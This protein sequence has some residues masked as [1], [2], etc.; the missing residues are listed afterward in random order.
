[1]SKINEKQFTIALVVL[2]FI[3][4]FLFIFNTQRNLSYKSEINFSSSQV[5]AKAKH[6]LQ[7]YSLA[8]NIDNYNYS[9]K[10]VNDKLAHLLLKRTLGE[11]EAFEFLQENEMPALE[12]SIRFFKELGQ[13]E[14]LVNIDAS[15]G[16]IISFFKTISEN[17]R[18]QNMSELRARRFVRIYLENKGYDLTKFKERDFL[19]D[20]KEGRVDY[21]FI[22]R[23]ED[24]NLQTE[25]GNMHLEVLISILG[26]KIGGFASYLS[27]PNE[28]TKLIE[29]DTENS[30]FIRMFSIL[31]SIL[32][33]VLAVV[34]LV[35]RYKIGNINKKLFFYIAGFIFTVLLIEV[36]N[37]IPL[38]KNAYTSDILFSTFW[39]TSFVKLSVSVFLMSIFIFISGVSGELLSHKLWPLRSKLLS[40]FK[41][42]FLTKPL[43]KFVVKG[44]LIAF[45]LLGFTTLAYLIGKKYFGIWSLAGAEEYNILLYYVPAFSIFISFGVLSV[46]AEEFLYRLFGISFFKEKFKKFGKNKST[47]FAVILVTII[48]AIANFNNPIYP[49]YF[50]IVELLFIGILISYFFVRYNIITVVIAHYLYNVIISLPILFLGGSF[51]NIVIGLLIVFLPITISSKPY[52]PI[53]LKKCKK[54][55]KLVFKKKK[56][57]K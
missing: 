42:Y 3:G 25:Y 28:F 39:E 29:S 35:T 57:K 5:L 31:A 30:K 11:K 10:F 37:S 36:I 40:N 56:R 52:W 17:H 34:V 14:F 20:K 22:F 48:W 13:D 46:F 9:I 8:D 24:L 26:N 38:I 41:N 18:Q 45:V 23:F 32:M 43:F 19:I 12:Y 54:I 6:F 44:Y 50:R 51:I 49:Y 33:L 21:K 47:F 1:M 4:L 55:I 15:T 7:E 16:K 2:A 27:V 53:A